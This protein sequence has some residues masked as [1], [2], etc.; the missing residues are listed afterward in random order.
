MRAQ[1][2]RGKS[3][4]KS[5]GAAGTAR[6]LAADPEGY[7]ETDSRDTDRTLANVRGRNAS[8]GEAPALGIALLR[9]A[10]RGQ[11]V[12]PIDSLR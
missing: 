9:A 5:I 12:H 6:G 7:A 10:E 4:A 3:R 11:R 2:V 1:L 8:D